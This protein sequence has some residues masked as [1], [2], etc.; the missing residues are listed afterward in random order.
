MSKGSKAKQKAKKEE[1][2][3]KD[4]Q[5]RAARMID[6]NGGSDY[7]RKT[8]NEDGQAAERERLGFKIDK[9]QSPSNHSFYKLSKSLKLARR[10]VLILMNLRRHRHTL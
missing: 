6:P 4:A 5:E 3:L 2:R 1:A 9:W 8:W 10:T 7:A